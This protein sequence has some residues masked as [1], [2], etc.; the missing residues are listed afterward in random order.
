MLSA[1][2]DP[3]AALTVEPPEPSGQAVAGVT[4][5][6]SEGFTLAL[7]RAPGG[8]RVRERPGSEKGDWS[9][10]GASSEDSETLGEAVRP[11]S[12]CDLTHRPA[13]K[14]VR[15]LDAV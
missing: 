8:V 14:A 12:L 9:K 1:V 3:L 11:A 2:A 15:R 4:V 5:V 10:W 13:L 6:T 7:D